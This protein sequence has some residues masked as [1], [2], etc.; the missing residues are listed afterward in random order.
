MRIPT[1]GLFAPRIHATGIH[2][3]MGSAI[4]LASRSETSKYPG[5]PAYSGS[6]ILE[7]SMCGPA[8][9]PT[10]LPVVWYASLMCATR[11]V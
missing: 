11:L 7:A 6:A 3:V 10:K 9:P 5:V 8:S 4:I 1:I 2:L